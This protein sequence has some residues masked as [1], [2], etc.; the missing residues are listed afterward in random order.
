GEDNDLSK[1]SKD[2]F[3]NSMQEE[4]ILN[5][6]KNLF[7]KK[8]FLFTTLISFSYLLISS[9]LIG[10]KTDQIFLI[11]I[12]TVLYYLSPY[13]RK[14]ITGFSIFIVFWILFDYLKA[15]P[16]YDYNVV[17]ILDLYNWEKNWFGFV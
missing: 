3:F 6:R 7:T 8:D 5:K 17:H 2:Q 13:T 14:F 9:L 10:F 4:I 1:R 15:F 12:C 16:N 11:L